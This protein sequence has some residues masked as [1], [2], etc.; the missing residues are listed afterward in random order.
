MDRPLHLIEAGA[1]VAPLPERQ[2]GPPGK[3]G[4]PEEAVGA[5]H[6]TPA[7]STGP[8]NLTERLHYIHQGAG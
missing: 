7:R 6:Q 3:E 1:L 5:Y 2:W 8:S 4:F